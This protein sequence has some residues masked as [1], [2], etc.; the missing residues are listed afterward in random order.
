MRLPNEP[1]I[2]FDHFN[3]HDTLARAIPIYLEIVERYP[4]TKAAKDA[5]YSAAVAHE[6]LSDLNPYWRDIY[7]R[8]L[9]AGPRKI[10]YADVRGMYPNYQLPASTY[11]WHPSTRTSNGGPGWAPAPK[12]APK[13]T[14][15]Q[16]AERILKKVSD[17]IDAKITPRIKAIE[18]VYN[19]FWQSC[20]YAL[21]IVVGILFTGYGSI[22]GY[23][24]WDK[25]PSH[26]PGQLTLLTSNDAALEDILDSDSRVAKLIDDNN[27]RL[28]P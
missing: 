11:G 12:P 8:G 3:S 10:N 19:G 23:Y 15:T 5:L 27:R 13:L 9:F 4:K 26:L 14:R 6:R 1:R 25:R 28:G 22:L 24:F 7:Q 20:C 17:V 21:L 16:R 2:L 18:D